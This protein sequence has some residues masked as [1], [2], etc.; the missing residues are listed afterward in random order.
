MQERH[1]Y[2]LFIQYWNFFLYSRR[3]GISSSKKPERRELY[4][5]IENRVI[6]NSNESSQKTSQVRIL[7]TS[8][9]AVKSKLDKKI[10]VESESS[11]NRKKVPSQVIV[12]V[13]V[14]SNPCFL[15]TFYYSL[16]T[17]SSRKQKS[18]YKAHDIGRSTTYWAR[19]SPYKWVRPESENKKKILKERKQTQG[20]ILRAQNIDLFFHLRCASCKWNFVFFKH[21]N[22][23]STRFRTQKKF[24]LQDAL[25]EL[26]FFFL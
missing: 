2:H 1:F 22:Q 11:Q 10:R 12:R 25:S 14:K 23:N 18:A 8:R 21:K 7:Q 6:I 20:F 15:P 9:V 24:H 19:F 17:H 16:S 26:N 3:K 4:L 13:R 5:L